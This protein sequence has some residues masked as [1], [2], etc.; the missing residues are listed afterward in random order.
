MKCLLSVAIALFFT[1]VAALHTTAVSHAAEKIVLAQGQCAQKMGPYLSQS[2]ALTA[3]Q[4]FR[5]QGYQTTGVWG[6][7]GVISQWSNR[8]YY[9]NVF[10]PC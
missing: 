6:E 7:G 9:F 4:L 5:E 1:V 8:R 10:Y 2:D 3:A